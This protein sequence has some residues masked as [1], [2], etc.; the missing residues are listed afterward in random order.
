[1]KRTALVPLLVVAFLAG[2]SGGEKAPETRRALTE[3]ERDST[4]AHSELPGAGVVG[5]AL[6]VADSASARADRPLPDGP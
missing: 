1:V 4:L 2:C 6:E 3:R 5:K